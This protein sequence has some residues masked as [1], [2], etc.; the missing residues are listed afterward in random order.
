MAQLAA[1]QFQPPPLPQRTYTRQPI[2]QSQSAGGNHREEPVQAQASGPSQE[3]QIQDVAA[4]VTKVMQSQ[5]G[6]KPKRQ[7]YMYKTPY[8]S[9]YDQIAYPPRFKMPDFTKFS[10]QDD[11]ST[12]EHVNRFI[13][14]CGEAANND[15]LRVWLFS[16]SLS[17]SAFQWFTSLPANSIHHWA[18]LEKQ[19]HQ[20]F[21]TAIHEMKLSDLTALR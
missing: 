9:H 5:F 13:I 16:L 1:E 10:G 15:A 20:F 2:Q 14:Q 11:T 18:D 4:E 8:P 6:L 12:V 3:K 19:F 17:G 21:Y 7:T